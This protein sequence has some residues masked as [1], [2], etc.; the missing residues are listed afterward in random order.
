MSDPGLPEGDGKAK[1]GLSAGRV[2]VWVIVGTIAI[3]LIV[4]GVIG[5]I[6]KG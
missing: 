4:S 1:G 5:I 3:Y 2:A 6:T